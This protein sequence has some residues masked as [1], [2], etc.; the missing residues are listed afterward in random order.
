[1]YLIHNSESICIISKDVFEH[2]PY[3]EINSTLSAISNATKKLFCIVPLG[4]NGKYIIPAYELDKT[5]IIRENLN[6]WKETFAKNNFKINFAD[7]NV[8]YI[9]DNW[10]S[11]GKGNGFFVLESL[12]N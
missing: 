12:N 4:E 11:W 6:W 1:M 7:Y 5:H 9:K 3:E 8:D 10:K 2:V